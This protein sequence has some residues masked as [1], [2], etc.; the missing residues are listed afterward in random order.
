MRVYLQVY[1]GGDARFVQHDS[2]LEEKSF[3]NDRHSVG[4]CI[5]RLLSSAV[6]LQHH[7]SEQKQ[8]FTFC[9]DTAQINKFH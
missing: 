9:P 5:H 4:P 6:W 3:C 2:S 7:R 1:S 8:R